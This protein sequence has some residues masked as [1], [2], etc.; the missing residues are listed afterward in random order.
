ML[1][2]NKS[3]ISR[4]DIALAALS[5]KKIS[6]IFNKHTNEDVQVS[7]TVGSDKEEFSLSPVETSLMIDLLKKISKG[8]DVEVLAQ[9]EILTTQEAANIL[10]VSRPFMVK[11]LEENKIAY[12]KVGTHRRVYKEDI[13]KFKSDFKKQSRKRLDQIIGDSQDLGLYDV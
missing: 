11:L 6:K 2:M 9:K 3:K 10:N 7:I 12:H 8:K 13:L 4:H 5:Y 1:K